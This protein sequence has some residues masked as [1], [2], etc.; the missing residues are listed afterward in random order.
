MATMSDSNGQMLE[1]QEPD[2]YLY[3]RIIS[4]KRASN[5]T[6]DEYTPDLTNHMLVEGVR[7]V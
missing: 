5:H 7:N 4:Q 1:S 3:R 6:L 2:D